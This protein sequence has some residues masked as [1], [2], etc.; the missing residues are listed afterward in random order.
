MQRSQLELD[1]N[2]LK[3]EEV[4]LRDT[5]IKIQSLNEGLGLDKIELNKIIIHLEKEKSLLNAHRA[6]L[7]MLQ[8]SLK[9][10]LVKV[11]QEKNDLENEKDCKFFILKKN[12]NLRS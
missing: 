2:K 3:S 4:K 11:E 9:S 12:C 8:V 7:E 5:I 1:F 6:E 10:E